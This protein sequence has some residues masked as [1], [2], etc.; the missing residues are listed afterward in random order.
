M[1]EDLISFTNEQLGARMM[2]L[3]YELEEVDRLI[4]GGDN[5]IERHTRSVYE[6]IRK[7]VLTDVEYIKKNIAACLERPIFFLHIIPSL[8]EAARYF[9]LIESTDDVKNIALTA[10]AGIEAIVTV[11]GLDKWRM[12]ACGEHNYDIDL[13]NE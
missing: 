1:T 10:N 3:I 13:Y 5:K 6:H 11:L 2:L 12:I 4:K 8:F 9:S 7:Q